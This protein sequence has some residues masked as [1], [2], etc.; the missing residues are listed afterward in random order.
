MGF[1][2]R[3]K[4][5][6]EEKNLGGF[7]ERPHYKTG[8]DYLDYIN[9]H[10]D[11]NGEL[12]LGISGG[13]YASF[14]GGSGSG[15]ST[16]AV[17]AAS[18]IVKNYIDDGSLVIYDCEKGSS[19][20]RVCALGA[21]DVMDFNKNIKGGAVQ[22]MNERT[23]SDA[24]FDLITNLHAAKLEYFT[25]AKV[26]KD[27]VTRS[28]SGQAYRDKL[29]EIPPTIIIVDSWA[30]MPPANVQE[31]SDMMNNMSAATIAKANNGLVKKITDKIYE[32]NIMV[33]TI[34][35]IVTDIQT[36]YVQE[37]KRALKW[38]RMNEN[39]PG[40]KEIVY[41]A[42]FA[43]RLEQKERLKK[44]AEFFIEGF[45][46]EGTLLKSRSNASGLKVP[47]VFEQRTGIDNV[48]TNYVFLKNN[49]MITGGGRGG[50]CLKTC[51]DVKFS[52]KD[53]RDV[54]K[55]SKEFR[56]AFNAASHE[57]L[58]DLLTKFQE[59]NKEDAEAGIDADEEE[60]TASAL[61]AEAVGKMKF[62]EL[63]EI[64]KQYNIDVDWREYD[65]K[66]YKDT[67]R[68]MLVEQFDEL[69]GG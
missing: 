43:L 17:Q 27:G 53:I 62:K 49:G 8:I 14:V 47:F 48:L 32:A 40:G 3:F 20:E 34:N 45:M 4:E 64:C 13:R 50:F 42:D 1:N 31:S 15:K 37:D 26:L 68:P 51:P 30:M 55:S 59:I 16:I 66:N 38:L 29:F 24:L 6:I 67:L 41:A 39:L 5:V 36:G 46:S 54:Y 10:Y 21:F 63:K 19:Y 44:D 9:G 2:D 35:H 22:I 58:N 65:V 18:N 56:K 61:T 52:Q 33:W 7:I 60:S 12:N 11:A 23:N 25:G 28:G 57:A 69:F